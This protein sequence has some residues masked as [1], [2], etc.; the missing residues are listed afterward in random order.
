M[1]ETNISNPRFYPKYHLAAPYGWIN[2]PNGFCF[3]KNRFHMFYQ[4]HP[5]ST[6]WGPMHW[7]HATTKDLVS[8]N[9]KPI[10]LAPDRDYDRDGC[11]S[12]SAIE[13]DG[14]L[15]LMYT[16]HV[17]A[18]DHCV[19]T[20]C[21]AVSEDGVTFEKIEG[22]PVIGTPEELPD[23]DSFDFRDPKVWKCGEK[24]YCV[25][26]SK[27]PEYIGQVVL[28]ESDDLNKWNFKSIAV[29]DKKD[30]KTMWECP[31]LA[32]LD[33]G[34]VMIISVTIPQDNGNIWQTEYIA[35]KFDY[36]TGI[37]DGGERTLIDFGTDFYAPQ[38][39]TTPDGRVIMIGWLSM[40]GAGMPEQADGWAG[41]MSIP[42]E[43][44]F[45]NG[46]LRTVPV[47]EMLKLRDKHFTKKNLS[48][49]EKTCFK[50]FRGDVGELLIEV[51]LKNNP[52]FAVELRADGD[53]RTVLSYNSE[54]RILKLDR[55]QSGEG[56]KNPGEVVLEKSDKLKLQ[57]FLDKSS[58]EIFAND[59]E[60]A[61]SARIYPRETSQQIFFVPQKEI[62]KITSA[63][64]YRFKCN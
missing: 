7:G 51:D 54:S 13:K 8:W 53:E 52:D 39:T 60:A 17:N 2:D 27:T 33:G 47:K 48:L 25:I 12:G 50:S 64:F 14:K 1:S 59:G 28:Y 41:M 49:T 30:E 4:Y 23:V 26:G 31:N 56:P 46:K 43:L 42:R 57:I 34:D 16:G 6:E 22:N 15:Y 32:E 37:F 61:I 35:G 62:L 5:Y 20:Q 63:T 9:N 58:I 21:F 11:F 24:Y 55:E 10:A 29:R 19:Q 38:I 3:Y 45:D 36:A 18:G 40:W 44:I